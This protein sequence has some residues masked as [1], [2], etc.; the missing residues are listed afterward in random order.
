MEYMKIQIESSSAK[1]PK[2]KKGNGQTKRDIK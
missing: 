1:T 2:T